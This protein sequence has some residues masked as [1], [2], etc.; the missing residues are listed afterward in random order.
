MPLKIAKF[1]RIHKLQ[2]VR[3]RNVSLTN[4]CR[5]FDCVRAAFV[6]RNVVANV[7]IVECCASVELLLL[8]SSFYTDIK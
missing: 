2:M 7:A 8:L 6:F 3:S 1:K 4:I 5:L